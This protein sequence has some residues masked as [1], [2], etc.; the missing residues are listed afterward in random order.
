[1]H[2]NYGASF[3][4]DHNN[5]IGSLKQQNNRKANWV[6]FFIEERL[7]VQLKLAC[8]YGRIDHA[9]LKKFESL[10]VKASSIIPPEKPSL[11]HGDLWSGNIIADENG[12][13][14]VIDPAVYYGHREAEIAFTKLF[15]GF[16]P[17]FYHA[18]QEQFPLPDGFAKR[19]DLYN[20]Y[21]LLVHANLFGGSYLKQAISIL[22]LYY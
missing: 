16:D 12:Q 6:E 22:N 18:Y 4:L 5:Y 8:D 15:G 20:L 14:C 13:P 9:L 19:V 2:K 1:L 11:L 17:E 10:S 21:P 3:G 7:S